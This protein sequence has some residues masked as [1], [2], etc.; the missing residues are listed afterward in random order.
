MRSSTDGSGEPGGRLAHWDNGSS[1]G[2]TKK[3]QHHG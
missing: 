1:S 2:D 3:A